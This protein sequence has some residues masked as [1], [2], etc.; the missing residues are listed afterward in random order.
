MKSKHIFLNLFFIKFPITAI[1]S[2]IHRL[3]GIVLF[4]FVPIALYFF[5]LSFE[6]ESS[7]LLSMELI[8]VFYVKIFLYFLIL[9]F[10]FHFVLGIKHI[11]MDFGFFDSKSASFKISILSL[12]IS[13]V[14]FFLS[15]LL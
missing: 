15:V 5:K 7:F 12:M 11:L 6:S 9:S 13:I 14:L 2:I 10:I 4:V 1:T 8:N 3:T